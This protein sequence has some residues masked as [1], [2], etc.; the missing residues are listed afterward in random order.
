[1]S[2][3]GSPLSRS[4]AVKRNFNH[5]WTQINPE[6]GGLKM[7]RYT[8]VC[9]VLFPLIRP[10]DTFSL[11]EKGRGGGRCRFFA[12]WPAPADSVNRK[13]NHR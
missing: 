4:H 3:A 11:G 7:G 1:M 12:P 10:A 6:D 9:Q 13:D 8:W 5:R 2:I